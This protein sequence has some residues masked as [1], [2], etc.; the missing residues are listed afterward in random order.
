[1]QTI[2]Y[3]DLS[4]SFLE[5][6]IKGKKSFEILGVGGKIKECVNLVEKTIEGNG[7]TCRIYTEGRIAGVAAGILDQGIGIVT[8]VG[9]VAHN[10]FTL[11]PDYEVGKNLL[12]HKITVTFKKEPKK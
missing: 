7:L 1:M 4:S 3:D 8:A 10:L 6:M 5:S 2:K 12:Q 11:N 9:I